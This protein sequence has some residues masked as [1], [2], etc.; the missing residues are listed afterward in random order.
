MNLTQEREGAW[1]RL[2][3]AT[4]AQLRSV[5]HYFDR[6]HLEAGLASLIDAAS[7]HE[8]GGL[9]SGAPLYV[10]LYRQSELL[11]S[12]YCERW[13]VTPEQ[14]NAELPALSRLRNLVHPVT[15]W[16]GIIKAV[17]A[18]LAMLGLSLALGLAGACVRVGYLLGGGR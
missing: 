8:A 2:Q 1:V 4:A 10:V 3:N 16:A 15:H 12:A 14:L 18:V 9:A 17:L 7:G 6:R 13:Q 11:V 5:R